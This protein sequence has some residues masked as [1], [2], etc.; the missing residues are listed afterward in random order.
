MSRLA[1]S[2]QSALNCGVVGDEGEV[3]EA[4][5]GAG[6]GEVGERGGDH[7]GDEEAEA[8]SA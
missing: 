3:I 7:R 5:E 8:D 1:H 2:I 6:E 4:V